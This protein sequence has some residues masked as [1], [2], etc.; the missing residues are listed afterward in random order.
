MDILFHTEEYV[1][2]YRV[3]GICIQNGKVLLQKPSNDT[4]FAFPGGHVAFGETNAQA[5]LREFQEEI[6]V[7]ISVGDLKW[8]AEI[9]FPWGTKPCH[10][11]CLYYMVEVTSDHIPLEGTFLGKE[12]LEG[13]NF[14]LEF[15]WVPVSEL[16]HIEVYP[17]NV[18]ELMNQ[19][20]Q[21]V[22]HF[23]YRE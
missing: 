21:G 22:Q 4:A 17:T 20:D 14:D 19:M 7:D 3:A 8:V 15:H 16:E 12:K 2:S 5:L 6:G 1:F 23:I 18:V 13:R 10:Q 9:F 11:I